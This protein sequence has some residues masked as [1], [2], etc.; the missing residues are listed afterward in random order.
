MGT[1]LLASTLNRFKPA[2]W[3]FAFSSAVTFVV[4]ASALQGSIFFADKGMILTGPDMA[5]QVVPWFTFEAGQFSAGHIP[6]WNP[7][8]F[9]G[10]PFVAEPVTACFYPF[11]W[12]VAILPLAF[13]I[14]FLYLL[15]FFLAGW[16]TALWCK[17]RGIS[18]AGSILAGILFAFCAPFIGHETAG[19]LCVL[20]AMAWTPAIFLCI[21]KLFDDGT[22]RWALAG[23]AAVGLSFLSG[24]GQ[25]IYYTGI[26][27]GLYSLL[28]MLGICINWFGHR[29]RGQS[30]GPAANPWR[31]VVR[32]GAMLLLLYAGGAG[33]SAIQLLPTIST[34]PE[35]LRKNGLSYE[36]ASSCPVPPESLLTLVAPDFMGPLP[37]P[38][39]PDSYLHGMS[40]NGDSKPIQYYGRWYPREVIS[41]VGVGCLVLAAYGAVGGAR[42]SRRFMAVLAVLSAVL[43]L[44]NHT[45]L[46][47]ALFHN[48][49]LYGTFRSTNRFNLLMSLFIAVLAGAG[50]D[51]LR[52]RTSAPWI[53]AGVLVCIS[54]LIFVGSLWLRYQIE[55][56]SSGRWGAALHAIADGNEAPFVNKSDLLD[57]Q[58]VLRAGLHAA[59]TLVLPA[60]L[61]AGA[62]IVVCLI[63][64]WR[65]IVYLIAIMGAVELFVFAWGN[66]IKGPMKTPLPQAWLDAIAKLDPQ[67][68]VLSTSTATAN[69]GMEYGYR[70][71][72]GYDPVVLTRYAEFL[73]AI[74]MDLAPQ[75]EDM[76]DRGLN[77]IPPVIVQFARSPNT[78]NRLAIHFSH[79]LVFLR[80]RNI[81][82]AF[83]DSNGQTLVNLSLPTLVQ[84][85]HLISDW[86]LQ[87]NR[88][89]LFAAINQRDF[90]PTRTVVLETPPDPVP[91][92]LHEPGTVTAVDTNS[93][94]MEIT[95]DLLGPQILLITDSYAIG[96]RARSLDDDGSRQTYRVQPADYAFRAIPL[97]A[98]HHHFVL[99]YVPQSFIQGKRI[100]LT[101]LVLWL[102]ASVWLMLRPRK[103]ME[104]RA[105]PAPL[106]VPTVPAAPPADRAAPA[107]STKWMPIPKYTGI[108]QDTRPSRLKSKEP[109]KK[110]PKLDD[111]PRP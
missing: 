9:C 91:L 26:F 64:L 66:I 48:F 104:L 50:L 19:H 37:S 62:A 81:F 21:D 77:W 47:D 35:T 22:W 44:G 25:L 46:Y 99:E 111:P 16:F 6:L 67:G 24:F 87:P 107:A 39:A 89:A 79:R 18:A 95:A 30:G 83:N 33:L 57:A 71:A 78:A 101:A 96:W 2:R 110:P 23:A 60:C 74:Q 43:M 63:R 85:L 102:A 103:R 38:P 100:T 42:R 93:D 61:L 34:T 55:L 49:P 59:H 51:A 106:A 45:P 86:Q 14:N 80:C 20:E 98:G 1:S 97:T 94:S 5:S 31:R 109:P 73:A 58:F 36:M 8:Y 17:T 41:Y 13:C 70:D 11:H 27:A 28:R 65:P 32:I 75:L 12:I 40:I 69:M 10:T 15:H 56:D 76:L 108:R 68:R 53:F 7:Y 88:D 84:R 92:V 82:T 29:R 52:Q 72:Y 54:L 4:L 3:P 90:D 105:P